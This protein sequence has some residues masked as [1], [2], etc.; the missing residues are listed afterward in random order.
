MSKFAMFYNHQDLTPAA[1]NTSEVLFAGLSDDDKALAQHFWDSG[2]SAWSSAPFAA[3]DPFA[4][5]HGEGDPDCRILV[6][7]SPDHTLA[8]L[9]EL[10]VKMGETIPEAGYLISLGNDMLH[11]A[12]GVDPWPEGD[13]GPPTE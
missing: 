12:G 5:P 1:A 4:A 13:S 11:W 10:L 2:L 3:D 8:E 6:I 9:S 7:D